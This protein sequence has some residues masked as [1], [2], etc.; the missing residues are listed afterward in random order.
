MNARI[1]HGEARF[2]EKATARRKK[3]AGVRQIESTMGLPSAVPRLTLTT[4]SGLSA[5]SASI[6]SMPGDFFGRMTHK[7]DEVEV[8]SRTFSRVASVTPCTKGRNPPAVVDNAG[9]RLLGFRAVE[10]LNGRLVEVSKRPA[11]QGVQT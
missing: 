3:S 2:A 9:D 1:D 7:V 6:S 10:P 8:L 4:G 5:R 11:F